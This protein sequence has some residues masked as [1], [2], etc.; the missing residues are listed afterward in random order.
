MKLKVEKEGNT[1]DGIK[2]NEKFNDFKGF[3][4]LKKSPT[5]NAVKAI[6]KLKFLQ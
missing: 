2:G 4:E 5:L 6:L 3:L 1:L